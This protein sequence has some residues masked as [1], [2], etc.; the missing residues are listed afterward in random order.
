MANQVYANNMEVSCKAASGKSVCAFPDVCFT[1]P[2]TPATPPG[3]PIPYP[4]TGMA[5]DSTD[6]STTVM[7]SGEEV[8]LKNKSCFKKST[9]D[10]AGCAPKK[11]II[12]GHITGK[13]YFN[14]WS[15]DVRIEGENVVRHLDLMTHNHGSPPN[16]A[17]PWPYQDAMAMSVEGHPCKGMA[18]DIGGNCEGAG[19]YGTKCCDARKCLVVP[20]NPNTC[21]NDSTG[22]KM[23]PHHLLPS[24]EFVAH[25]ARGKLDPVT[26]YESNKGP[27]VCV[28]GSSHSNG[29][30]HGQVGTNYTAKKAQWFKNPANKGKVYSLA[31]GIQVAAKSAVGKI[32]VPAGSQGCDEACLAKQLSD[33]HAKMK[34][35]VGS[36]DPLPRAKQFPPEAPESGGIE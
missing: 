16:E 20:Y 26:N 35:N 6:G 19:D 31:E 9:G 14:S 33:G 12:N 23:T 8:M 30:E 27:C 22:K 17:V 28:V 7:I 15:M 29:T 2:Q 1:P 25:A 3:V 5:S 11:G 36:D 34:L 13:V 4:N 21:C 32:D 18:D 24:K 10:E